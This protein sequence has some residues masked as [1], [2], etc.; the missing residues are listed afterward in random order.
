MSALRRALAVGAATV[1]LAAVATVTAPAAFAGAEA[2]TLGSVPL[3]N[4][5]TW[6]RDAPKLDHSAVMYTVAAGSGFRLVSG[7]LT[8]DGLVWMYGH[9]NGGWTDGW[10]PAMN[11]TCWS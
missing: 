1:S 5:N 3:T 10:V 7:P 2:C 6:V 11:L 4:Q 9:P 8:S